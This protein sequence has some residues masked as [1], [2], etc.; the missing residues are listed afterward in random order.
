MIHLDTYE[1]HL[2]MIDALALADGAMP[3]AYL[4]PMAAH[5][6][7]DRGMGCVSRLVD[8]RFESLVDEMVGRVQGYAAFP[9]LTAAQTAR[10][11]GL[12]EVQ[13]AD[14]PRSG[15]VQA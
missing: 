4:R 11:L 8:Q 2:R 12:K 10:M 3:T 6:V 15:M 13:C 14:S 7:Y 5:W 9:G 1:D